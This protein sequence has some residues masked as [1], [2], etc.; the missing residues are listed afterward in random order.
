[1]ESDFKE[2]ISSMENKMRDVQGK[3]QAEQLKFFLNS[4]GVLWALKNPLG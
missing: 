1:M 4:L 3:R 2:P